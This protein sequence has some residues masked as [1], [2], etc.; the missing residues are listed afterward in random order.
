VCH[1]DARIADRWRSGGGGQ[2]DQR[3]HDYPL[4]W[5]SLAD[6]DHTLVARSF[7]ANVAAQL[8]IEAG[9]PAIKIL[10]D[11]LLGAASTAPTSHDNLGFGDLWLPDRDALEHD[12]GA[13]RR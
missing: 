9:E 8:K 11:V 7:I 3:Y 12:Q 10:R 6:Q 2:P 4:A 5:R 1:K 13:A